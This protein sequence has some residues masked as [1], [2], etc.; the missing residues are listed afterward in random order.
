MVDSLAA[1]GADLQS[2]I[3]SWF[4]NQEIDRLVAS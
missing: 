4:E 1:A 3:E 2:L